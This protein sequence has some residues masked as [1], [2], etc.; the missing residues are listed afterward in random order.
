MTTG[1]EPRDWPTEP[2]KRPSFESDPAA[3]R[4]FGHGLPE[5]SREGIRGW[6]GQRPWLAAL[7]TILGGL[8]IAAIPNSDFSVVVLPGLAGLSGLFLGTLIV[9]CGLF[10]LFSPQIHG[11]IGLATVM[12]S[13]IAFITTNLGGLIIGMVLGIV[14]GSMGFAW[15][16]PDH[17]R[18]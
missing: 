17:R 9:A 7:L 10:L 11:L 18:P 3:R 1:P 2:L 13:L 4:P 8:A 16:A 14:G 5:F 15:I 6:S 12:L